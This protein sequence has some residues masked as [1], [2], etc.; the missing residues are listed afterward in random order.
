METKEQFRKRMNA[1]DE[2]GF[3]GIPSHKHAPKD[4][5]MF[6]SIFRELR[7]FRNE[8]LREATNN[9]ALQIGKML[10]NS[11]NLGV[12]QYSKTSFARKAAAVAL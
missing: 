5:Y 7:K 9:E 12:H 8:N 10:E 3:I 2:V 4:D 1:L 6:S 11:Y